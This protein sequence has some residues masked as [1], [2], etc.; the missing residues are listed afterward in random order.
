MI[1]D[2]S[3]EFLHKQ[4]DVHEIILAGNLNSALHEDEIQSFFARIGVT[5]VFSYVT[6][7]NDVDRESTFIKEKKC[8]DT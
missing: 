3:V 6:S 5:D 4:K 2:N 8:I 7:T 1:L